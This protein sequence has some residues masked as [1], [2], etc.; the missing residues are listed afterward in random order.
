MEF[1]EIYTEGIVENF[2]NKLE[3]AGVE[4]EENDIYWRG[5]YNQG[6]GACFDFKIEGIEALNFLEKNEF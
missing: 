4:I 5:F 3:T 6:D 2:I 1:D